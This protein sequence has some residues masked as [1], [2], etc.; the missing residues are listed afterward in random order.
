MKY[1]SDIVDY[2]GRWGRVHRGHNLDHEMLRRDL[3][4][5]VGPPPLDRRL[6][7]REVYFRWIPRI[8]WC[9]DYGGCDLEGEWHSHWVD[10]KPS[11]E[12]AMTVVYWSATGEEHP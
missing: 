5:S 9:A 2:S 7:T 11:P 3:E 6:D 1:P 4:V 12:R 8:M 10:V